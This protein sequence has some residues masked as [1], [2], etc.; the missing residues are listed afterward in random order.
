MLATG[1]RTRVD[2]LGDPLPEGAI[3][4][5]GTFRFRSPRPIESL[6]WARDGRWL[7]LGTIDG[8]VRVL[9]G[10][11]GTLVAA[12]AAGTRPIVGLAFSVDGQ[13]LTAASDDGAVRLW[14]TLTFACW[15]ELALPN[16]EPRAGGLAG[17]WR[18]ACAF[19]PS[20]Q[21]LAI[22]T[23]P[24]TITLVD[25][26]EGK[27]LRELRLAP[28]IYADDVVL[29]RKPSVLALA[30]S[31]DGRTL[32][33]AT[34]DRKVRIFDLAT[35][36]R[37]TEIEGEGAALAFGPHGLAASEHASDRLR[38]LAGD[39]RERAVVETRPLRQVVLAPGGEVLACRCHGDTT[40][41][42]DARGA[43]L[44][45]L[46]ASGPLSFAPDGATLSIGCG[47]LVRIFLVETGREI[48]Q[49]EPAFTALAFAPDTGQL[50][51]GDG[52]GTVAFVDPQ[53]GEVLRRLPGHERAITS[54]AFSKQGDLATAAGEDAVLIREARGRE[55]FRI[56]GLNQ[57]VAV[58]S[59]AFSP[60]GNVLALAGVA[61]YFDQAAERHWFQTDGR[62]RF[63]YCRT[64]AW[65][66]N[67]RTAFI[68]RAGRITLYDTRR[69]RGRLPDG[70]AV[71]FSAQGE[72]AVS[73]LGGGG[74][75]L[76]NAGRVLAAS[77]DARLAFSPDGAA[78]VAAGA[79][80]EI[81]LYAVPSGEL[82]ALRRGHERGVEDVAFAADGRS[83]ATLGGEGHVLVWENPL[84]PSP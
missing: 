60:D 20:G 54:I 10:R 28:D 42:R 36:Q 65:Q 24:C 12:L 56:A 35:G 11:T 48:T 17:P 32:A 19:A 61:S 47:E 49:H 72:T 8:H 38:L 52:T 29:G 7:A 1:P 37:V 16:L 55:L 2:R 59:I 41:L 26:V 79:D 71:A 25:L 27:E 76:R 22:T 4:R 58:H 77:R 84:R 14:N 64:V 44:R 33:A 66:K 46:H 34:G 75:E 15:K 83:F 6:A 31:P 69:A 57:R 82:R 74:V 13:V 50:A 63:V 3:A 45:T 68:D 9:D 67:G 40:D 5:I 73:L 78:L 51:C 53:T 30:F 81:R 21:R 70:H 23:R 62:I 43:L 39:G 80:G 18:L